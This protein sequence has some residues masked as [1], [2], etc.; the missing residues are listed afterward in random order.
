M[1]KP[2]FPR[3]KDLAWKH[4]NRDLQ[5]HTVATDGEGTVEQLLALADELG[6]DEIAFTEHVRHTSDYYPAFAADVR[7]KRKSARVK[8]YVGVE[9][10]VGNREG[11]LDVSPE[12]LAEAEIVLGSVHRFPVSEGK[13]VYAKDLSYEE[14]AKL[15]LDFTLALLA[16]G[17]PIDVLAHP[18]GMCQRAFGKFPDENF[19]TMMRLAL[20]RGVAVEINS[21]YTRDMDGFLAL[22]RKINPLIS[23]GSDVHK[24]AT[25]GTCRGKLEERGVARR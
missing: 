16:N 6:L 23:V 3:F 2:E 20:E 10:K 17:A 18:G 14:A 15:E 12:I 19:E 11:W 9:A 13:L 21:S 7:E 5:V 8:A 4:I 24:V 25:L 1:K 22:C